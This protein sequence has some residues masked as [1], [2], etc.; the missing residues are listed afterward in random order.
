MVER[1]GGT[2]DCTGTPMYILLDDEANILGTLCE[3]CG[4][5]AH[6]ESF[7]IL[8]SIEAMK[9]FLETGP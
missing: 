2:E 5:D 6:A 7:L 1:C 3:D 4:K 9:T 8:V